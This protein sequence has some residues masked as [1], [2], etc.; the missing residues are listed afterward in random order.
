M[1]LSQRRTQMSRV[2]PIF[3][4]SWSVWFALCALGGCR[5][6]SRH[7]HAPV[8]SAKAG[9]SASSVPP[10]A[11]APA[12]V[13][14]RP[15]TRAKPASP[16][17][18]ARKVGKFAVIDERGP[19]DRMCLIHRA[20]KHQKLEPL[21]PCEV[22]QTAR[23]W[24]D[25]VAGAI[26]FDG[27]DVEVSG[28]LEF[29][30]GFFSTAVQ[31]GKGVCCNSYQK[32]VVLDGEPNGLVLENFGCAG[33]ESRLCCNVLATGQAVI[34]RGTL[35]NTRPAP[36]LAWSLKSVFVCGLPK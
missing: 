32:G 15:L 26:D 28:R 11:P 17:I 2:T 13:S 12:I 34:V 22:G 19:W 33:D 5:E 36:S 1:R 31:C 24:A 14:S 20:C 30:S 29:Q 7:G 3:V 23:P 4:R 10:T 35:V 25:F 6:S 21:R 18:R 8:Q 9:A 27:K 16:P